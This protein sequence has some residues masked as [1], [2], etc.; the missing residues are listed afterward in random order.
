MRVVCPMCRKGSFVKPKEKC[1]Y[2]VSVWVKE[3]KELFSVMQTLRE[4]NIPFVLKHRKRKYA[5]YRPMPLDLL[6]EEEEEK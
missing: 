2:Q 3:K 5:I 4:S 1:N 6:P